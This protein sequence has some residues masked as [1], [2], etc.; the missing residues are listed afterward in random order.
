M[1]RVQIREIEISPE[2]E[3]V[4]ASGYILEEGSGWRGEHEDSVR[5]D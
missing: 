3:R 2:G 4:A 1:A 5:M